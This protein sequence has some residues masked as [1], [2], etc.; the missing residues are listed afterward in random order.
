M[1]EWLAQAWDWLRFSLCLQKNWEG[2]GMELAFTLEF[3]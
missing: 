3:D 1:Y 2:I